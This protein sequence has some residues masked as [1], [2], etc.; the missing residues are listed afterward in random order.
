MSPSLFIEI[1]AAAPCCIKN[2]RRKAVSGAMA[3]NPNTGR[4]EGFLT[5]ARHTH[6]FFREVERELI[7]EAQRGKAEYRNSPP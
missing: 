1:D 7:A 4:W 3:L 6:D 2:C 5:C